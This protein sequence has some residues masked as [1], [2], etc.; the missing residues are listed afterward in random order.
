[1]KKGKHTLQT[2]TKPKIVLNVSQLINMSE[3]RGG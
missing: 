1:M 3:R 2:Y